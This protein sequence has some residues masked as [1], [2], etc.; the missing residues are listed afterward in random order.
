MRARVQLTYYKGGWGSC[1]TVSLI[2]VCLCLRFRTS[3]VQLIVNSMRECFRRSNIFKTAPLFRKLRGWHESLLSVT[4]PATLMR[5]LGIVD[6]PT[7]TSHC[8]AV[9]AD[10]ARCKEVVSRYVWCKE[11]QPRNVGTWLSSPITTRQYALPDAFCIG[12]R[13][14]SV[15]LRV[16]AFFDGAVNENRELNLP[17]WDCAWD[18]ALNQAGNVTAGSATAQMAAVRFHGFVRNGNLTDDIRVIWNHDKTTKLLNTLRARVDL[19]LVQLLGDDGGRGSRHVLTPFVLDSVQTADLFRWPLAVVYHETK[20][21]YA[22]MDLGRVETSTMQMFTQAASTAS[23]LRLVLSSY[24]HLQWIHSYTEQNRG[25][26]RDGVCHFV[27]GESIARNAP[28]HAQQFV[29]LLINIHLQRGDTPP[30]RRQL[31]T[32]S[33]PV[34]RRTVFKGYT[35][36]IL[37]D[38]SPPYGRNYVGIDGTD[39]LVDNE[40]RN[41]VPIDARVTPVIPKSG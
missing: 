41:L 7:G 4:E 17:Q 21:L 35:T 16:C 12:G 10:G 37:G 27:L 23:I 11:H 6:V 22:T 2:V 29:A 18:T 3:D 24:S 33:V 13:L 1:T 25:T 15:A 39:I 9:T 20:L 8:T 26:V 32:T 19:L 14:E 30:L 5:F 38:Q 31:R 34:D 40:F 28:T 36:L